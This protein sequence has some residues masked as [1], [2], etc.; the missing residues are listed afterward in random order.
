MGYEVLSNDLYDK[1]D[2]K[3]EKKKF[4]YEYV[5]KDKKEKLVQEEIKKKSKIES[6]GHFESKKHK[7]PNLNKEGKKNKILK[8]MSFITNKRLFILNL[9][10]VILAIIIALILVFDININPFSKEQEIISITGST[11]NFVNNYTGD[12]LIDSS[13]FDLSI[14][15]SNYNIIDK[16][17]NIENFTGKIEKIASSFYFTG[18]ANFVEYTGNK[19]DSKDKKIRLKPAKDFFT[20]LEFNELNISLNE[21]NI[22]IVDKFDFD[23]ETSSFNIKGFKVDLSFD[24]EFLLTGTCDELNL[25][26]QK[27]NLEIMYKSQE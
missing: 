17:I 7:M 9:I 26:S 15:D 22:N 8:R 11:N 5:S 2:K 27:P 20:S 21:G 6:F 1:G 24:K 14:G 25:I 4:A 19:L 3:K 23:F 12:I 18:T 13:E 16:K 10:L